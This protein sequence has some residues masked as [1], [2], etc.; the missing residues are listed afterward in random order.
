MKW[1]KY[2]IIIGLILCCVFIYK[3]LHIKETNYIESDRNSQ[4]I[5]T[6]D[7]LNLCVKDL[8]K[9]RDSLIHVIDTT[10]TEITIIEK[11][12][13]K[14]YIDVTNQSIGDDIKFFSE[15]ISKD[16]NRFTDSNYSDSIK[17]D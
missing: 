13:E 7:S 9:E 1:A 3:Q 4:L 12:Y 10:K 11:E 15:Y 2:I 14:E 8:Y 16:D 5:H 6:I 17:K